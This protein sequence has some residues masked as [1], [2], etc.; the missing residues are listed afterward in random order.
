MLGYAMV[1]GILGGQILFTVSN[2]RTAVPSG[3]VIVAVLTWCVATFGMPLFHLYTRYAWAVQAAVLCIMIGCAGPH[4][5]TRRYPPTD[6][7]PTVIANRLSF[8]SLCFSSAITWAP[9]SADYFVY[10]P[11]ST[12]TPRMVLAAAGAT[13]LGVVLTTV[14]GIGLA[15]GITSPDGAVFSSPGALL[16]GSLTPLGGVGRFC[17]VLLMLGTVS[18]N[19]PCTYS[20]GLNLQMLGRYGPC[21]PRP[22]L[23][24]LEVVL[25]TVCAVLGRSYLREILENFLPLMAYWIV[26][27]L[28]ICLEETWIFRRARVIDWT[29]WNCRTRLPVGVAAGGSL[30]LGCLGGILG[31]VCELYTDTPLS[32]AYDTDRTVR[33]VLRRPCREGPP[34]T[35]RSRDMAVRGVHGARLPTAAVGGGE[36]TGAV[37]LD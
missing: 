29:A 32:V 25:Y 21:T 18:N 13:S 31:M 3:I 9:S 6:T 12:K 23:T 11:P 22:L 30:L 34:C 10:F 27:W 14:L 15:T 33:V 24:T 17:A 37:I 20:A 8:F 36:G 28:A 19:I 16:A 2:G 4:F 35:V 7:S 26:A 1:N 5:D